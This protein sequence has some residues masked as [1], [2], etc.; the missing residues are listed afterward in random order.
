MQ[1]TILFFTVSFA[2]LGGSALV[3]CSGDDNTPAQVADAGS[4]DGSVSHQDGSN[5]TD[6]GTDTAS[7]TDSSHASTG[8]DSG[9]SSPSDAAEGGG[10]SGDAGCS[11]GVLLTVIDEDN[12]CTLTV[13]GAAAFSSGQVTVCVTA[14]STV[15][16]SAA[17]NGGFKVGPWYNTTTSGDDLDASAAANAAQITVGAAGTTA[18]AWTCCP[19]TGGNAG[20][21]CPTTLAGCP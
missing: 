17:P 1:R 15:N 10:D 5:A 11:T 8:D 9:D 18:C 19:G 14:N 21:T 2:T 20:L 12:W 3:A 16:L 13:P 6:T 7:A 4:T